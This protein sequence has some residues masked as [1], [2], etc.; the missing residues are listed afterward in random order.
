MAGRIG[1]MRR[2]IGMVATA[3]LL[4]ISGPASAETD[5]RPITPT[6]ADRTVTLTGHDLSID[7]LVDIARFGAK[8]RVAD[9]LRDGAAASFGLILQAQAEKVPVYLFNRLPGSGREQASL[10][11]DPD[12][13]TFK[14]EI[15]RRYAPPET[16]QLPAGFGE[17]IKDE[18]VGRAMLAVDLNN[19][20]YLA[21]SPAYV[22]GIA[23]L[24]NH[25]VTPAVYWRGAIGEAD[26][27]PTGQTLRGL[28]LAYFKGR[29][30]PAAEALSAAG[31]HPIQFAGADGNLVTT[32]ALS[33]G[34]AA[35]LVYDLRRFL[36]WH[37][38]IWS[39][40]LNA[41][42]GS[43]G[44]LSL[45]VQ[46]TRPFPWAN[47]A[48]RRVLEMLKG[49]YVFNGEY[50]IIQDP[51]SL[52]ATVWRAGSVWQSWAR[53]RDTVLIQM[54]ST[55]HNP[56]IRPGFSPGDSW[57]LATPQLLKYHVKGGR[58]SNGMGGYILSNS[59]WDPY[60]LV[61]D[62]EAFSIPLTNLM[63]AVVERVH[64]FEDSFFTVTDPKEV[65]K[66]HGQPGGAS[67]VGGSGGGGGIIDALWQELKPLA[68]PVA[69]DGVTAD[70]GVGDLDAVPML[71][72]MRLRQAMGIAQDMLGQD[73]LNAAFWMDIRKLED[74]ARSFGPAPTSLWTTL[75]Q[76][77]PFQRQPSLGP[78]GTASGLATTPAALS[79][80]PANLASSFL[81]SHAPDEF[82]AAIA[83]PMPGGEPV[84]PRAGLTR[85][86]R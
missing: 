83:V 84:I 41:M 39:M 4:G 63:V 75:R 79:D 44:P 25:G 43:I 34:F 76:L 53:L 58:W 55:D 81:R 17:D 68:N 67:G 31:L 30:M 71:K 36:G 14:A 27:V 32:S 60:P 33:A 1:G 86:S 66:T 29:R 77:V 40:D 82:D 45:P 23:D 8:V 49:S 47:F 15:A 16:P 20:R 80:T 13:E 2:L 35:L 61:D 5:Y 24:L 54:N 73:M 19:M 74:P 50:R 48:A 62:V 10:V 52:R 18:E 65:L 64:R 26:F 21:A 70:R 7:Q 56:T 46:S 85:A 37:D 51:E 11:G 78:A 3:M 69:P 72:L 12:S 57:E 22:Q 42:N 9:E 28:G 38:L 59:N 6:M